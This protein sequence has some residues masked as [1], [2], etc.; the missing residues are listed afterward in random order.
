MLASSHGQIGVNT[1]A[2]DKLEQRRALRHGLNYIFA[3]AAPLLTTFIKSGSALQRNFDR[4]FG[5]MLVS[6]GF[7]GINRMLK[8]WL[9]YCGVL[10]LLMMWGYLVHRTTWASYSHEK[11]ATRP[12]SFS[13]TYQSIIPLL[14]C[15]GRRSFHRF[16]NF[17]LRAGLGAINVSS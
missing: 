8:L 9:G 7:A 3:R 16:T 11:S 4:T 10:V 14:L 15:C 6:F 5:D 12:Y 13:K 2:E 17:M 1:G